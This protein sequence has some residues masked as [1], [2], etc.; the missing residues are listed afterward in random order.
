MDHF[1]LF[2][3][4]I[5]FIL[6]VMVLHNLQFIDSWSIVIWYMNFMHENLVMVFNIII[7][8][9]SF[10]DDKKEE[11]LLLLMIIKIFVMIISYYSWMLQMKGFTCSCYDAYSHFYRG[12]CSIQFLR[13]RLFNLFMLIVVKIVIRLSS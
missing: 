12:S 4:I 11:Y 7:Y 9:F 10:Y 1:F 3:I 8:P 6:F 5:Y 2:Y 13:G